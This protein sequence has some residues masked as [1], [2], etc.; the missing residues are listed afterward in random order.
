MRDPSGNVRSTDAGMLVYTSAPTGLYCVESGGSHVVSHV[1]NASQCFTVDAGASGQTRDY[2]VVRA[3]MGEFW[4]NGDAAR[5]DAS[6]KKGAVDNTAFTPTHLAT[7]NSGFAKVVACGHGGS[8]EGELAAVPD[9]TKVTDGY[10]FNVVKGASGSFD[11][12]N[13]TLSVPPKLITATVEGFR[14]RGVFNDYGGFFDGADVCPP[15]LKYATAA[16]LN[17]APR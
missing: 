7:I 5:Y 17:G 11:G 15:V 16:V 13:V 12:T 4:A 10:D 14:T 9:R 6:A 2:K 3:D 1:P 8:L